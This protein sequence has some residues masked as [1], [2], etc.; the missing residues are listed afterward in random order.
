M[1][2]LGSKGKIAKYIGEIINNEI[3]R[4]EKSYSETNSGNNKSC[5]GV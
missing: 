5:G 3:S 4:R 2:Y 1:Q